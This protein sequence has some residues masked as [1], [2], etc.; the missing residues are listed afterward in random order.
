MNKDKIV[1]VS[2]DT[3]LWNS[4]DEAHFFV[5][6]GE[7]KPLPE[8]TTPIIEDALEQGL[9]REAT[10]EEIKKYNFEQEVEIA[11]RE[12][13]IKAGKD[14]EDTLTNFQ[15]Y[16]DKS[17]EVNKVVEKEAPKEKEKMIPIEEQDKT[18]PELKPEEKVEEK[19]PKEEKKAE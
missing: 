12:H 5:K 8:V 9:L 11:V 10:P 16:K 13:K 18:K 19:S 4:A 17:K 3:D 15:K 14:Y 1:F 6:K 7:V 2:T